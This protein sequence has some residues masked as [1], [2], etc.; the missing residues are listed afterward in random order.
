MFLTLVHLGVFTKNTPL[1][2]IAC[3]F[4]SDVPRAMKTLDFFFGIIYHLL[5]EFFFDLLHHLAARGRQSIAGRAKLV[6]FP[7]IPFE[8]TL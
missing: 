8:N 5:I 4:K 6:Y 1:P 2:K 7:A 3:H